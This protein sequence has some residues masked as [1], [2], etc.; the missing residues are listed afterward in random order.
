[1][2]RS[3]DLFVD[4]AVDERQLLVLLGHAA[5]S[6]AVETTDGRW[7]L[8]LGDQLVALVYRHPYVDD[9]DL[10]LARYG[11]VVSIRVGHAGSLID[12]P[13]TAALRMVADDLRAHHCRVLLVLDLQYRLDLGPEPA[14]TAWTPDGAGP[15]PDP[16]GA[17]PSPEP[18]AEEAGVAAVDPGGSGA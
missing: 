2:S 13:A 16:S 12:H 5:H 6:A 8:R 3:V 17:A 18:P 10:H 14:A 11:W 4:P 15:D 1:M 7:Q 9:G